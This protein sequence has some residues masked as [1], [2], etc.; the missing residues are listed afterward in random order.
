ML[1]VEKGRGSNVACNGTKPTKNILKASDP[2]D[3]KLPIEGQTEVFE[4]SEEE[5]EYVLFKQAWLTYCWRRAKNHGLEIDVVDERLQSHVNQSTRSPNSHDAVDDGRMPFTKLKSMSENYLVDECFGTDETVSVARMKLSERGLIELGKLGIK[6]QLWED[7]RKGFA[8]DNANISRR[9]IDQTIDSQERVSGAGGG[10]GTAGG[11]GGGGI[12]NGPPVQKMALKTLATPKMGPGIGCRVKMAPILSRPDHRRCDTTPIYTP[13]DE[14]EEA[15][16]NGP[17]SALGSPHGCLIPSLLRRTLLRLVDHGRERIMEYF[18]E[19]SVVIRDHL[20]ANTL[21][22]IGAHYNTLP[23][24]LHHVTGFVVAYSDP[25]SGYTVVN[26]GGC[27]RRTSREFSEG[28]PEFLAPSSGPEDHWL[29]RRQLYRRHHWLYHHHKK[30]VV[31]GRMRFES[32]QMRFERML[33]CTH[34]RL[35]RSLGALILF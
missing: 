11:G 2:D 16:Y 10:G 23:P 24:T 4:L 7:S 32:G 8:P 5:S 18:A 14:W 22:Q 1:L 34:F 15:C 20:H 21:A 30:A 3:L 29:C 19:G 12:A 17:Q 25:I 26:F 28:L 27:M 9:A 6:D 13:P 33:D 35:V 31:W